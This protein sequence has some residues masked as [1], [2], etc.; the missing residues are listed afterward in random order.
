MFR[1]PFPAGAATSGGCLHGS[2]CLVMRTPCGSACCSFGRWGQ[3]DAEPRHQDGVTLGEKTVGVRHDQD[4][5]F[6]L[7]C[8]PSCTTIPTHPGLAPQVSGSLRRRKFCWDK[9]R[10]Y[11]RKYGIFPT[12]R[13]LFLSFRWLFPTQRRKQ[14][15]TAQDP[16]LRSRRPVRGPAHASPK[17]VR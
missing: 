14:P 3:T 6:I 7:R 16:R 5:H 8:S 13:V 15:S 4:F 9:N 2:P 17:A 10:V 11:A 12:N 1:A